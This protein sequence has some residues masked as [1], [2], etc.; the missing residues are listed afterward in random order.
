MSLAMLAALKPRWFRPFDAYRHLVMGEAVRPIQVICSETGTT[1]TEPT[2]PREIY[3]AS[4][5]I[6][7]LTLGLPLVVL[8]VYDRVIPNRARETLAILIVGLA[9]ALILDL[10]LRTARTA[11]LGWQAMCFVRRVENE[12][13]TRLVNASPGTIEREPVAVHTNRF[14]A[15]AAL[16]NYH[17]GS[18]RLLA[19]DIPFVLVTLTILAVVGGPMIL[20]PVALF[21][22]FA[23]LA[24]RRSLNFRK[25]IAERSGQDNRKYDFVAEV[26]TGIFTVKCMAME[27]QM[28]RRFERLQQRVAEI[29]MRSIVVSDSAQSSA[30]VYGSLSQ[31][32]VVTFGAIRVI[33]GDMSIGAL[34]CCT[35]LSGQILQPLLR[36]ISLWT[37]KEIVSH[38]RGEIRKLLALPAVEVPSP[39]TSLVEGTIQFDRVS[40]EQ[41]DQKRP[42]IRDISFLVPAGKV[43]GIL[44]SDGSAATLLLELL[45]GDRKPT[46]GRVSIDGIATVDKAFTNT[47]SSVAYV[48]PKPVIF[49]GTILDNLTNF[50]P[51]KRNYARNTAMLLGLEGSV[52][53]LPDGYD[54][55]VGENIAESLPASI[56]QQ[57]TIVRALATGARVLLLDHANTSLDRRAEA[58]L[59]Q[60]ID[61]LRGG[62]TL[63]IA[64]LRPSVLAKSDV[65]YALTDGRLVEGRITAPFEPAAKGVA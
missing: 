57:I 54:T 64:T 7:L 29:A 30:V 44:C 15:L 48:G 11:L 42:A 43:V 14:A 34:A 12:A 51:Q 63:I 65:I 3:L 2:V 9:F 31:I 38:R 18:S 32:A 39:V 26:L 60:A 47:R 13:I 24:A 62:L 1:V 61:K 55:K 23:G 5:V 50:Q 10:A 8:Q 56:A 25:I 41:P 53:A 35:M 45:L 49:S 22:S 6:N 52:N 17:A 28:Q 59:I 4:L 46:S 40:F 33:D 19:I 21:F 36:A 16:G 58:A 37:D 20:V 27:P